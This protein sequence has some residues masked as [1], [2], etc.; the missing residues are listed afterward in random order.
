MMIL[1][2]LCDGNKEC[3]NG[4]DENVDQEEAS[5]ASYLLLLYTTVGSIALY[6]TLKILRCFS[7]KFCRDDL[8]IRKVRNA[9]NEFAKFE[10]NFQRI[11]SKTYKKHIIDQYEKKHE[12]KTM[13][14]AIN[15]YLHQVMETETEDEINKIGI[16]IFDMEARVH[17]NKENEIYC[18][19]HRNLDANLSEMVND[20]KFP[21]CKAKSIVKLE[22]Y[23]GKRIITNTL[24]NIRKNEVLSQIIYTLKKIL[25]LQL[26]YM[27][28]FKAESLTQYINLC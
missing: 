2:T 1:A 21:G 5:S 11:K 3:R 22:R 25:G 20:A 18:C 14:K 6:L 12:N 27:D 10:F 15:L 19:L 17:N 13:I 4:G 16:E 9:R 23:M 7:F 28:M 8:T 26:T 24:N